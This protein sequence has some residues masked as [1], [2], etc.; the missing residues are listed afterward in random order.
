M[1][2]TPRRQHVQNGETVPRI[3]TPRAFRPKCSKSLKL[4]TLNVA[5]NIREQYALN[6][7]LCNEPGSPAALPAF[8]LRVVVY[9]RRVKVGVDKE[10]VSLVTWYA[11]FHSKPDRF[12]F[13]LAFLFSSIQQTT[14]TYITMSPKR[15]AAPKSKAKRAKPV[16]SSPEVSPPG[17]PEA[18]SSN[19][20]ML[21][22]LSTETIHQIIS[23][24]PDMNIRV[25]SEIY[26]SDYPYYD[27]FAPALSYVRQDDLRALSQTCRS[28]RKF[29][30]P[31]FW[32]HFDV[33]TKRE[34]GS[35]S[36]WYERVP[37]PTSSKSPAITPPGWI[38][39][40]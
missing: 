6:A 25:G 31:L 17:S 40:T 14:F 27:P 9:G 29:F 18:S 21:F 8:G 19:I 22:T 7:M 16:S 39:S 11:T 15:K 28:F 13:H 32:E 33:Y 10:R 35:P 12:W 26:G 2:A 5:E 4:K 36:Q 20:P 34:N 23:H 3:H 1:V 24:F 38:L 37:P 30:G